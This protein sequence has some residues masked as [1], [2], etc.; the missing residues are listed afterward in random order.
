MSDRVTHYLKVSLLDPEAENYDAD[1]L[2]RF[3][4]EEAPQFHERYAE[5][6]G[7][8]PDE[9]WSGLEGESFGIHFIGE[10][11]MGSVAESLSAE[12]PNLAFDLL[13]WDH[14]TAGIVEY[15]GGEVWEETH[16]DNHED[17]RNLSDWHREELQ[18][19]LE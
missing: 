3:I 2:T 14:T 10:D 5:G 8:D 7:V 15:V 12:H 13:Y 6:W 18:W 17:S 16:T 19:T 4:R 9:S 11:Y 1:A